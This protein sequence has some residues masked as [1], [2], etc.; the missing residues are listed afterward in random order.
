MKSMLVAALLTLKGHKGDIREIK[1]KMIEM[2]G[3]KIINDA[4]VGTKADSHLQ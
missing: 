2:F 3:D 1:R 4:S